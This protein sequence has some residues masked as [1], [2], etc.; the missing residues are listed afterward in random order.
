MRAPFVKTALLRVLQISLLAV[1]LLR[2]LVPVGYM[3]AALA[4]GWPVQL[5][6]D[7]LSSAAMTALLGEQ[8]QHHKMHSMVSMSHEGAHHEGHMMAADPAPAAQAVPGQCDLAAFSGAVA[9][10]AIAAAMLAPVTET[11]VATAV[12]TLHVRSVAFERYRGRAPPA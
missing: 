1:L 9:P 5:C 2:V 11:A 12:T 8:H 3:P 4:D 7:G 6:P 10:P